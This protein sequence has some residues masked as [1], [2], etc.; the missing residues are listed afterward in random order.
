MSRTRLLAGLA[1]VLAVAAT[2]TVLLAGGSSAGAATGPMP[3]PVPVA[4][5]PGS[6]GAVGANRL[7]DT[8]IGLGAPKAALAPGAEL[9]LQVTGRGGVPATNVSSVLLM[10][11]SIAPTRAGS[12]QIH[13]SGTTAGIQAIITLVPGVTVTN[14][15]MVPLGPD[16]KTVLRNNSS[17]TVHLIA[18]LSGY[19]RGG[20]SSVAGTMHPVTSTRL[21]D[22]RTGLGAAKAPVRANG[23]ITM[24]AT[25]RGG[26]PATPN[27][28]AVVVNVTATS[29][30]KTG[31]LTAWAS[32]T[33][34]PGISNLSYVPGR[35]DAALVVVKVGS[36]GAVTLA[37]NSAGTTQFVADVFG[38]IT[39]GTP[40]AAGVF[41]PVTPSRL[42]DTR[43]GIGHTAGAVHAH[44]VI[45]TPVAGRNGLPVTNV[46]AVVMSV[47]VIAPTSLG[48]ITAWGN[49]QA[50]PATGNFN[51]F[52]GRSTT[53]LIVA[54]VG[55]DG[56]VALA[57]NSS[58]TVQ[59]EADVIGYYRSDP[60]TVTTS[61]SHYVRNLTG[62]ASDATIM[63]DEGCSDAQGVA[64][65]AQNLVTL[66]IGGQNTVM[67]GYGVQLTTINQTLTDAQL[68]NAVNGY[69]DG[70]LACR[71]STDP[72]Y[73]A[74]ATNNDGSLRNAA[75]G[76]DWA[77]NVVDPIAAHAAGADGLTIAG[78]ND[79]EPDFTG[80]ESEAEAWT[81]AFLAATSAPYVFIG[82]ATGC[83]TSGTAACKYGWT[84]QNF[85]ALAH[86]ISPTRILAMPQIYYMVN[87]QQWRYIAQAGASG[88]DRI[89]FIGALSE[90]A[91]CQT[92]GSGCD[93][94]GLLTATQSW[95]ALRSQL[96]SVAAVNVQR[97]PVSTDLR[98]D[99]APGAPLSAN[100]VTTAGVN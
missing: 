91:A 97:L 56:A 36:A 30:T 33:P 67:G 19:Y 73:I 70:Y 98:I 43:Y 58:G 31:Y 16:G 25:G 41:A 64:A 60:S 46:S 42:L 86:G 89:S 84:R 77:D 50:M 61:T 32:G 53:D 54:P 3:P 94:N 4:S 24:Q 65:G 83:P 29:A 52:A 18:D 37:N 28:S 57:N 48:S 47:S 62:G 95:Q 82:A 63:H 68:V 66:D 7:L 8:R 12:I 23:T 17:G 49:G 78:A 27:V 81:R 79:I 75:A 74:V 15:A 1:V 22:T 6:Y 88:A 44:G 38:Y 11:A 80:L 40:S 85:Y 20:S 71:T 35:T 2:T 90:Y 51:Y 55:A 96:S 72:A 87:A 76:T 14:L 59:I 45:A 100:R 9:P 69:V 99:S 13:P 5:Q 92:P 26:I 21:L 10:V 93:L 39:S 34:K